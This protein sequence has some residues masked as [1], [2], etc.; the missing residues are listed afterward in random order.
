MD[1]NEHSHA[2]LDSSGAGTFGEKP[3]T[4]FL[5]YFLI[6]G[7]EGPYVIFEGFR[8]DDLGWIIPGVLLTLFFWLLF[9]G[10]ILLK[11][12]FEKKSK[13]SENGA[14]KSKG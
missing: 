6:Y 9:P 10:F 11:E 14:N 1:E 3:K 2:E 12:C 8:R 13:H 4:D 5:I 7:W